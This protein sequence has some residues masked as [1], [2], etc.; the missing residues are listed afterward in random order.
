MATFS[1]GTPI[2]KHIHTAECEAVRWASLA[3]DVIDLA[4][5]ANE[6]LKDTLQEGLHWHMREVIIRYMREIYP[7]FSEVHFRQVFSQTYLS[8]VE[9]IESDRKLDSFN[10][11]IREVQAI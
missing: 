11:M 8:R 5:T 4:T 2:T 10:E 9:T 7:D 1:D 6:E 3:S